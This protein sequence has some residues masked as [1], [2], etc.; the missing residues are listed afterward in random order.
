[1]RTAVDLVILGE[2]QAVGLDRALEDGE[3]VDLHG[4]TVQTLFTGTA[5]EV[6][7]DTLDSSLGEGGVVLSHV[8]R[9]VVDTHG[10]LVLYASVVLTILRLR[11]LVGVL[12]NVKF[13]H[14][15][16]VFVFVVVFFCGDLLRAVASRFC[17]PRF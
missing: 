13:K 9:H 16:L 6:A 1:M 10:L 11:S 14:D 15:V 12:G 7:Q 17:Q 5:N 8:L 3:I 4:V 2:L